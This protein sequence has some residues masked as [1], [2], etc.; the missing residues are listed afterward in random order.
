M[1][2]VIVNV[3]RKLTIQSLEAK[4][5]LA[6]DIGLS[7]T[8]VLEIVGTDDGDVVEVSE[9]RKTITVQN[10]DEKI[11]FAWN[12]VKSL[13][14]VGGDGDD[15]FVNSTRLASVAYGNNG[16]DTLI[17]GSKT[18]VFHG[19]PDN[20]TLQGRSGN[21]ELHGDYGDDVLDGGDGNDDLRGWY[22]NDVLAGGDGNDYLS[23]YKG[24][25]IIHGNGGNDTLKGHDGNDELFGDSGNDK[26]YGWKGDDLLDGGSGNDYLSAWSGDDILVGG[27]GKDDLRGHS[28]NDVIIGGRD[29]DKING[30][31]GEDFVIT[32]STDIDNDTEALDKLMSVWNTD[33]SVNDRYDNLK[34]FIHSS[35]DA[36]DARKDEITDDRNELDLFVFDKYD[37]FIDA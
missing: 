16:N 34:G 5:L 3:Y 9:S 28:G 1:T 12:D 20:D 33:E 4:K 14:F 29:A 11:E 35:V 17:G 36:F 21:D 27:S 25:D 31:S 13:S 22:G 26:I 6:A 2:K 23:G 37:V 8:G 19:G 15:T 30:G 24:D 7:D 10:G 32:G 18:D